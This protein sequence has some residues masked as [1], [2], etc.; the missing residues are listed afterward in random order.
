M[1]TAGT[2][3]AAAVRGGPEPA[4]ASGRRG[5]AEP[6]RGRNRGPEVS[7]AP[8]R[9]RRGAVGGN[10]RE[11][12]GRA[13][14]RA[15]GGGGSGSTGR[16]SR[17]RPGE[18]IPCCRVRLQRLR[19]LGAPGRGVGGRGAGG[20]VG[21]GRRRPGRTGIGPA[22]SRRREAGTP[23]RRPVK[24]T[25]RSRPG[26]GQSLRAGRGFR[27]PGGISTR[28]PGCGSLFARGGNGGR[29]SSAPVGEGGP[30]VGPVRRSRSRSVGCPGGRSGE[31]AGG[32]LPGA[33]TRGNRER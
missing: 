7:G 10:R 12:P 15:S 23:G 9:R 27:R 32:A 17:A 24:R 6:R 19:V 26:A 20:R 13:R 33:G 1:S 11:G 25:A 3:R 18:G 21:G 4:S 16:G 5:R 31:R 22:G 14:A 2:F 30:S 29:Q 28:I 8:A